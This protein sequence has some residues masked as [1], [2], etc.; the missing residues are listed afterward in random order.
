MSVLDFKVPNH[1]EWWTIE[2]DQEIPYVN[3]YLHFVKHMQ[4]APK[5]TTMI[6]CYWPSIPES[7]Y[8][9]REGPVIEKGVVPPPWTDGYL[10]LTFNTIMI[11]LFGLLSA[12]T[13][14]YKVLKKY[15][16]EPFAYM[17]FK[18]G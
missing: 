4:K 13:A 15:M 18:I 11:H 7:I 1:I 2:E 17:E 3:A 14:G 8:F 9:E 6:T 5:G 10:E 16:I 12:N